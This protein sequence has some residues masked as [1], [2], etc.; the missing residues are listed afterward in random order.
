MEIILKLLNR[1]DTHIESKNTQ[2]LLL[3]LGN[4]EKANER[5]KR[6][7]EKLASEVAELQELLDDSENLTF[8]EEHF[9]ILSESFKSVY[10]NTDI[11]LEKLK[12][13]AI[14]KEGLYLWIEKLIQKKQTKKDT[15]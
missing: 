7:N 3:D 6:A 8:I 10:L 2:E 14:G 12:Q 5:I 1:I 13:N 4:S 11:S 9:D 15:L